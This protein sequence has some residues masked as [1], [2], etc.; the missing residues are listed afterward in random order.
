[1]LLSLPLR[2]YMIPESTSVLGSSADPAYIVAGLAFFNKATNPTV[3]TMESTTS[4]SSSTYL[5][6][7]LA[8]ADH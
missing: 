7:K 2:L 6:W 1:M 8:V 4:V 5:W 3:P